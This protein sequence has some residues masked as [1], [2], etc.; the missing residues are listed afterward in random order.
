MANYYRVRKQ[1]E[2]LPVAE[3]DITFFDV[4]INFSEAQVA[5]WAAG[6]IVH[7][8]GPF[9]A[10]AK[11]VLDYIDESGGDPGLEVTE[12]SYD[13]SDLDTNATPTLV[14]DVSFGTALTGGTL[15]VFVDDSTAGQDGSIAYNANSENGVDIGG[16]YLVLDV[17]TAAATP[18]AGTVRVRG[19]YSLQPRRIYIDATGA[20]AVAI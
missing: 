20:Q 19:A 10:G 3:T 13:F 9:P 1:G 12:W 4:T 2:V 17:E 8:V 7:L 6:D 16:K 5:A 15:D 11:V 14:V 18:A